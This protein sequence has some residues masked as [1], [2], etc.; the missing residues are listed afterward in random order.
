MIKTSTV[1]TINNSEK[2]EKSKVIA[3]KPLNPSDETI[4][5]LLAYSKALEVNKTQGFGDVF[6][7]KN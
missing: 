4:N 7:V 3:A 2:K 6:Q 1:N 5:F